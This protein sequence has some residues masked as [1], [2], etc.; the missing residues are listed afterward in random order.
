MSASFRLD[1]RQWNAGLTALDQRQ[2]PFATMM[3]VNR[4]AQDVLDDVRARMDVVF[5]RPTRF[6]KNAFQIMPR[7]SRANPEAT[8][9]ERPSVTKRHY[10]KVQETGGARGQTGV[11]ALLAR[12]LPLAMDLRAV[13]PATGG[14]FEGARLDSFGNWSTGERNQVLS[15][16]KSQRDATAN[17]TDRSRAR[18]RRRASYFV[19]KHG[20]APGVY[21]R[22]APGDIP[23]RVLKFSERAPQYQPRLEF[24]DRAERIFAERMATNF[25][26]AL[27]RALATAR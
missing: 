4:T 18:N 25:A 23:V 10:L 15:A 26:D 27:S 11:E 20:L 6:T 16:L 1:T 19:P 21:R 14:P 22:N 7:A 12:N 3:A 2:V 9:G 13:I 5:D 8:V 17:V 24:L